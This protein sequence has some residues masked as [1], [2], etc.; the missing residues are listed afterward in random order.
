MGRSAVRGWGPLIIAVAALG[1]VVAGPTIW[2]LI[3]FLTIAGVLLI[4]S[5]VGAALGIAFL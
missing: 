4:I 2:A 3:F 1:S 5:L